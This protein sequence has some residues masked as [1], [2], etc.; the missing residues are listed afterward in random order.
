LFLDV[1]N[2]TALAHALDSEDVHEVVNQAMSTL[3]ETVHKY[4]G[5]IDKFTG[6]GL[7]ALFGAPA[8]H[9]ND[10]ERAIRAALEMQR[11]LDPLRGQVKQSHGFDLRVRIG[12]NTGWVI[13]GKVG[14]SFHTEYTVIGDSVNLA[15]RLESAA[16]PGAILVSK[17]TYQRTRSLFSFTALAPLTL[18]GIPEPVEAYRP[19]ALLDKSSAGQPFLESPVPMVGREVELAQVQA[20]LKAV[21]AQHRRR[22]VIISGEAGVGKSKLVAEFCRSLAGT[23]SQVYRGGCLA[24]AQASPLSLVA[25]LLRSILHLSE[26]ESP[27]DQQAALKNYL[28]QH[29]LLTDD[30]WPYLLH[31]LGLEQQDS[32]HAAR[33]SLLDAAMLQQQTH[34]AL[35][36]VFLAEARLA[37][38]VLIFEDLHWLDTA[39]RNFLEYLIQ[40]D[41]EVPLLLIFVSRAAEGETNLQPLLATMQKEPERFTELQLLPLSA[42][43]GQ[44]LV[45]HFTK[46]TTSEATSLGRLIAERAEGNPFFIEEI[47]RMLVDQGGLVQTPATGTW[48]VTAEANKLLIKIP[49]TVQGLILARFDRLPERVRQ[50]LQQAAV[51]GASFPVNLLQSLNGINAKTLGAHLDELEGRGFLKPQLFSAKP[52]YTFC[53]ALV[54]ETVYSTLLN[55]DRSI[56]HTK[57]GEAIEY[58]QAWLPDEKTEMLAYHYALGVEPVKAVPY[59]I[60]AA[61]NAARR[62]A[63]DT[64]V[65]HYRRVIRLTSD[66]PNPANREFFEV[67]LG[68]GRAL[69]YVGQ[70]TEADQILAE[71]IRSLK[72]LTTSES[73]MILLRRLLVEALRESADVRQRTGAFDE[74]LNYLEAGLGVLSDADWPEHGSLRRS[75]LERMA[76]IRF[77]QGQLD[78]ASTLA[79]AATGDSYPE[80]TDDPVVLASLY[81]TLGGICW[82]QGLLEKAVGYVERSLKLHESVGYLWGKS[83]AHGNLGVLYQGLGH[84]SR[85]LGDYEQAFA[86][87]ENMGDRQSQAVNL[88]NLGMVRMSMGEHTSARQALEAGLALSRSVGA[89]WNAALCHANLAELDIIQGHAGEAKAHV[90]EALTISQEIGS[91]EIQIQARRFLALLQAEEDRAASLQTA[92]QALNMAQEAKLL[93]EEANCLRLLGA[94]Y[95]AMAQYSEAENCFRHSVALALEQ[96]DPYRQALAQLEWGRMYVKLAKTENPLQPDW[97]TKAIIILSEAAEKFESLGAVHDLHLTQTVLGQIQAE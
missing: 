11:A 50:T 47:I 17:E 93:A 77:R 4:E 87:Q 16:E 44:A 22:M 31:G 34:T 14:N 5:T 26:A 71:I 41:D 27:D 79:Q 90:D 96:T 25:A 57:V 76:W 1:T 52:G 62:C 23:S 66:Q 24:Y 2:F 39:S 45:A 12:I 67:R 60:T 59:L 43:Q 37:P 51:I 30:V 94:L 81:N 74:A 64:A 15:A 89:P 80:N 95:A 88:I 97:T 72:Q 33:L 49:G 21:E 32:K 38:T 19:L 69:K 7:M 46:Q 9:E 83:V 55:R 36:Q 56:F 78:Q 86:L 75:L 48:Q 3:V 65:E 92:T 84:W 29:N 85:A 28:D 6:D 10:P 91:F 20:V 63:Y 70:L 42:A 53:H 68:L 35:R 73:A 40:T 61:D 18:K 54:Q 82:Q 13:A 58:S 8:A